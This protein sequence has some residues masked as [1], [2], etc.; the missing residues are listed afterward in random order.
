MTD[1]T[2]VET[3]RRTLEIGVL[4]DGQV[5]VRAPV[6]CPPELIEAKVRRRLRWIQTQQRFFAQFHPRTPPRQYLSGETH[7]YLGKRYRLKILTGPQPLVRLVGAYFLVEDSAVP[8]PERVAALMDRWYRVKAESLFNQIVD[9]LW[10]GHTWHEV[11]NPPQIKIRHMTTHWGSLATSGVLSLNP[12]LV[13]TPLEC[14]EYVI[15]HELCHLVHH[16]HSPAFFRLLDERMPD[17][18]KRKHKLE[19]ALA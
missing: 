16:D 4:P 17:W 12:A 19:L 14:I 1:Y 6:G 7:F 3:D 11:T 18:K 5:V 9:R 2:V 15:C 8:A 10:F 13:R